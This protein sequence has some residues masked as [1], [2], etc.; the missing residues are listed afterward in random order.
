MQSRAN[1]AI[2]WLRDNL[3]EEYKNKFHSYVFIPKEEAMALQAADLL[4]WEWRKEL[5]N[6]MGSNRR[7]QRLSLQNILGAPH[8][9][10]HFSSDHM[11]GLSSGATDR[12]LVRFHPLEPRD[13]N[14]CVIV[15]MSS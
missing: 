12:D 1:K 14:L 6:A 3:K 15:K 4:A 9:Y 11:N 5:L 8:A 10:C 13:R 7:P 2:G